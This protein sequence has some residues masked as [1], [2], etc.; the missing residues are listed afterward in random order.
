MGIQS[1]YHPT[2]KIQSYICTT[3]FIEK[4]ILRHIYVLSFQRLPR[5]VIFLDSTDCQKQA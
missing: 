3:Q 4:K 5:F 1:Q 2:R